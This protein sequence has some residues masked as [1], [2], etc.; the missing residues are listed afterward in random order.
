MQTFAK[1][2]LFGTTDI[3]RIGRVNGIGLIEA[4]NHSENGEAEFVAIMD[5]VKSSLARTKKI[6][7][8]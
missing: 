6:Q 4:N 2:T 7:N 3:L 1:L 5:A 8:A